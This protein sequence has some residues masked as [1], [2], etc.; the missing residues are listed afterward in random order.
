MSERHSS[1]ASANRATGERAEP[2]ASEKLLIAGSAAGGLSGALAAVFAGL[3]CIGPSSVALL[4]AGGALAA[5]QL[6]PYRPALLLGAL[7]LLAFGFWRAYGR[8]V[9]IEGKACPVRAGRAARAVLWI[10][11]AVWLTA[12]LLPGG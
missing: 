7:A 12:A 11:A 6:T 1:N 2:A 10:S 4:G 9:V 5:A 8:R 3:C